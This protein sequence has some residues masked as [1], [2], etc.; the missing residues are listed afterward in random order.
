LGFTNV[1]VRSGDGFLGWPEHAPFDGIVVA[2]S[3]TA[4]PGPLLAQLKLGG[5]LVMPIGT[6]EWSTQLLRTTKRLDGTVE[7]CSLGLA[8]F[9]PLTGTRTTPFARYGLIDQ[10]IPLCFGKPIIG[11]L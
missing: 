11:V 8:L 9:V 5:R 10:S 6:T 1:D 4:V 2:A 7:R 3:A